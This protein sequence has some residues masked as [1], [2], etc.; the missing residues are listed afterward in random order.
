MAILEINPL[1]IE[2]RWLS[3]VALDLQTTSSTPIGYNEYGHMQFDTVRPEIA[4][5]LHRLKNHADKEAAR[6]I[7]EPL[8]TF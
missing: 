8:L 4:Q 3:G 6:P 2:G 1:Q 7:I 5:Y